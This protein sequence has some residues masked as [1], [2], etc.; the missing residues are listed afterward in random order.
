[1]PPSP[2]DLHSLTQQPFGETERL[3]GSDDLGD[4]AYLDLNE[5]PHDTDRRTQ[6]GAAGDQDHVP[7]SVLGSA[8]SMLPSIPFISS[9]SPAPTDET[10]ESVSDL[11]DARHRRHKSHSPASHEPFG[12]AKSLRDTPQ[13]LVSTDTLLERPTITSNGEAPPIQ[14][15]RDVVLDMAGYHSEEQP[16]T[17]TTARSTSEVRTSVLDT[18][19]RD[20]LAAIPVDKRPT[21]TLR[22]TDPNLRNT[23]NDFDATRLIDHSSGDMDTREFRR[24]DR[25]TSEPP[26]DP[27]DPI[28]PKLDPS[29]S[30]IAMD[31]AWD[32]GRIPPDGHGGHDHPGPERRES[33]PPLDSETDTIAST[34]RLRNVE[35]NP[36]LFVFDSDGRSHTF[37][38]SLSA[39]PAL[40]PDDMASD[41]TKQSAF[42]D[43]RVTFQKFIESPEIVDDPRLVVRYSLQ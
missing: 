4:V 9:R 31:Y 13:S 43:H 29:K 14:Y 2:S 5:T 35:E 21:M 34:A 15:G 3:A 8:K 30:A 20:L 40:V 19:A 23:N 22:A 1:M 6:V 38:L 18:F 16:E 42:L 24:S 11:S 27:P 32:W 17:A 12:S 39:D 10:P 33:L 7:T 36:Y 28:S 25:A 41:L 37:E 26:V